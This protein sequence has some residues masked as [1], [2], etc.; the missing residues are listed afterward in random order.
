MLH[1]FRDQLDSCVR[2]KVLYNVN[3]YCIIIEGISVNCT[4]L[5]GGGSRGLLV[6]LSVT[7]F[8]LHC[9]VR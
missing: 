3:V 4:W 6:A 2:L 5:R 8:C 1:L 7:V 9:S